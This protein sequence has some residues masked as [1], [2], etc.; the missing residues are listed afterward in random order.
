MNKTREEL[1][2][3][4]KEV[5]EKICDLT[6]FGQE[7][8]PN[9]IIPYLMSLLPP[10][11]HREEEKGCSYHGC[12]GLCGG[13]CPAF[14]HRETVD[15]PS[16]NQTTI[17]IGGTN[18]PCHREEKCICDEC[19][20]PHKHS[21]G[22]IVKPALST[23]EEGECDHC[24]GWE[25]VD[26]GVKCHKCGQVF[27]GAYKP[28]KILKVSVSPAPEW[29]KTFD[30]KFHGVNK[31]TAN[32]KVKEGIVYKNIKSFISELLSSQRAHLIEKI[33]D[34]IEDRMKEYEITPKRG[35]LYLIYQDIIKIINK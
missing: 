21:D 28:T 7:L 34:Q 5:A 35:D 10:E 4:V 23:P 6:G 2:A 17:R 11:S 33:I 26:T 8:H 24:K 32:G 1:R 25:A 30:Y 29:E 31:F 12:N 3:K 9:D 22:R 27:G 16:E 20:F 13:R 18:T 15:L 19:P 14:S